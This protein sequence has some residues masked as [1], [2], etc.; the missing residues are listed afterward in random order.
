MTF[1]CGAGG[2]NR[3][4]NLLITKQWLYQLSYASI[5]MGRGPGVDPERLHSIVPGATASPS[6]FMHPACTDGKRWVANPLLST[7]YVDFEGNVPLLQP[8]AGFEPAQHHNWHILSLGVVRIVKRRAEVI[9]CCPTLKSGALLYLLCYKPSRGR[10]LLC[11]K[12][13]QCVGF[14]HNRNRRSEGL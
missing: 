6:A 14:L 3:I 4:R 5:L 9:R 10:F 11:K 8:A 1:L 12:D 13:M 2:R 7:L